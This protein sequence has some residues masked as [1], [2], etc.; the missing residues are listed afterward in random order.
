MMDFT[1]D[2]DVDMDHQFGSE[3]SGPDFDS[4]GSHVK[5][6]GKKGKSSSSMGCYGFFKILNCILYLLTLCLAI[7]Y[8]SSTKFTSK[9]VY[10]MFQGFFFARPSLILLYSLIMICLEMRRKKPKNK[11][12][13][14]TNGMESDMSQSQAD[15]SQSDADSGID[16][17]SMNGSYYGNQKNKVHARGYEGGDRDGRSTAPSRY[18]MG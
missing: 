2:H 15:H 7:G 18:P 9:F 12:K 8:F 6:K 16:G 11:D 3:A 17:G 1:R 4:D 13:K 10:Y 14:T 5:A